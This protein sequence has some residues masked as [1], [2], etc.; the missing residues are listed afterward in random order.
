RPP[1][2]TGPASEAPPRPRTAAAVTAPADEAWPALA[3][4]ASREPWA[5]PY[6]RSPALAS[7]RGPRRAAS[8]RPS[9]RSCS[10]LLDSCFAPAPLLAGLSRRDRRPPG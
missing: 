7:R 4:V 10:H 3:W 6:L 5:E 8:P 9:W 2:A 1:S